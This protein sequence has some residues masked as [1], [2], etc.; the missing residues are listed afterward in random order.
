MKKN[1]KLSKILEV[2]VMI[3]ILLP[4]IFSVFCFALSWFIPNENNVLLGV[5]DTPYLPALAVLTCIV[6]ALWIFIG[7]GINSKLWMWLPPF[8]FFKGASGYCRLFVVICLII[9]T[10]LGLF[11]E[12]F[13]LM[14]PAF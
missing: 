1:S 12:L 4:L 8:V 6:L 7:D 9:G 14:E 5:Y 11:G 13:G 2:A 3:M 10:L